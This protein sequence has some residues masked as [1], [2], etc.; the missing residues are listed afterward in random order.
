LKSIH[1]FGL[2]E[3]GDERL[4]DFA[5]RFFGLAEFRFEFVAQ[6]HELIDFVDDTL[7]FGEGRDGHYEVANVVQAQ[8]RLIAVRDTFECST[9]RLIFP[10]FRGQ[11][12]YAANALTCVRNSNSTGL[13]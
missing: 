6:G 3:F 12:D 2:D 8:S 4:G 9:C 10:R 5:R 11:S 7:L 1:R 13:R